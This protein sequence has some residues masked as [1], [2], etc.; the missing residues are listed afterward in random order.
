MESEEIPSPPFLFPSTISLVE[1]TPQ[2]LAFLVWKSIF[3]CF[4]CMLVYLTTNSTYATFKLFSPQ[5]DSTGT[6]SFVSHCLLSQA[7]RS[8]CCEIGETHHF[9]RAILPRLYSNIHLPVL[10][11]CC[12]VS[13]FICFDHRVLRGYET[14]QS[15]VVDGN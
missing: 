15:I 7:H 4:G 3:F 5:R 6:H 13:L 8:K 11:F 1:S 14:V 10:Q 12:F 9:Y 2:P